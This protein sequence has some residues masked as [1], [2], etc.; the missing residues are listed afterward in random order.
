MQHPELGIGGGSRLCDGLDLA[1]DALGQVLD[2]DTA[3]GGLGGEELGVNLVEGRK[4]RDVGQE[5]SGLDHLVKAAAAGFQ[6]SA[7]VLAALLRL[8]G[9]ATLPLLSPTVTK[10]GIWRTQ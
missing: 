4:I 9:D 8:C 3:A 1:Q 2:G 7:D 10:R 5:A 6:N